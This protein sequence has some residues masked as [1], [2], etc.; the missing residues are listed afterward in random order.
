MWKKESIVYEALMFLRSM[1]VLAR[2]KNSSLRSMKRREGVFSP[3]A[4]KRYVHKISC[5]AKN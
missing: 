5:I 2:Y 3:K 1:D 4:Q